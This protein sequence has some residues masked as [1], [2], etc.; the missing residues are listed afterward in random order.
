MHVEFVFFND[1]IHTFCEHNKSIFLLRRLDAPQG[2]KTSQNKFFFLFCL[3]NHF[4]RFVI[5]SIGKFYL[6]I[7]T[8]ADVCCFIGNYH[9][10]YSVACS[11][12]ASTINYN[13]LCKHLLFNVRN[14]YCSF[15][16]QK[17]IEKLPKNGQRDASGLLLFLNV[18]EQSP[19]TK[20][21]IDC[22]MIC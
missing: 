17:T 2:W 9:L 20:I 3:N 1:S 21:V 4:S 14:D 6:F 15:F 10:F 12:F 7:N 16:F 11:S 18:F 13:M 5:C 22:L 8:M 19:K